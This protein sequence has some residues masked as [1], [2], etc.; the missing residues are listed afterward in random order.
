VNGAPTDHPSGAARDISDRLLAA[1]A[2]R[3]LRLVEG[4][5]SPDCRWRNVP[6]PAAEGRD[7]VLG[8]LAP[9]ITWSDRVQWDVISAAYDA[10]TAWLE[11]ADRFWIDGKEHTVLCNGVFE[12][13]T[14]SGTVTSVRDYVDLAE[15]RGRLT[16]TMETMARRSAGEVV[17]RHLAA[18][19]ARDPVAMAADY[20]PGATIERTGVHLRGYR[21]IADY[22]DTVPERLGSNRLTFSRSV[23]AGGGDTTSDGNGD[24]VDVVSWTIVD[25]RGDV[26]ATGRDR[27][28]VVDGRIVAQAVQLDSDDF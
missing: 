28:T 17:D 16:P 22:F 4:A 27:F 2:S 3:D 23:R 11:R 5:L 9:V 20:A 18:V 6:E 15:W 12:V 25:Q 21:A 8:L 10:T 14:V 24:G 7:A 19:E 13:D 1:L 26:V